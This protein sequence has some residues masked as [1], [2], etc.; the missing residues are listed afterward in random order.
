MCSEPRHLSF[1][2]VWLSVHAVHECVRLGCLRMQMSSLCLHVTRQSVICLLPP[3][4]W[5]PLICVHTI[6]RL[7]APRQ[8]CLCWVTHLCL[9]SVKRVNNS[10][11]AYTC[12]S[13]CVSLCVS[14]HSG[15]MLLNSFCNEWLRQ[16]DGNWQANMSL[17]PALL[18]HWDG[19]CI[20]EA[21]G[22]I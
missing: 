8:R 4:R 5:E 15:I 19:N 10:R 18:C 2:C 3:L 21:D 17:Y 9:R 20:K 11:R 1:F 22:W 16:V 13:V 12:V 6:V 7:A 14:T